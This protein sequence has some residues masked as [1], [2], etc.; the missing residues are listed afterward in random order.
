MAP[1]ERLRKV[2]ENSLLIEKEVR[3]K[4]FLLRDTKSDAAVALE[5][6]EHVN[7]LLINNIKAKLALMENH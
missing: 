4:E 1:Q 5:V 2:R 6:E 7:D 3:R